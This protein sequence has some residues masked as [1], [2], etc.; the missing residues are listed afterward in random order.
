MKAPSSDARTGG[1]R[2]F[3]AFV[4]SFHTRAQAAEFLEEVESAVSNWCKGI[5]RPGAAK[6]LKIETRSDG[7]VPAS[8]W[9]TDREKVTAFR[10]PETG[11]S[12]LKEK[13]RFISMG[14]Q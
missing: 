3:E 12:W 8:A 14:A 6:R 13:E 9:L 11:F 1:A 2:K 5:A 7:Q 4:D 10:A